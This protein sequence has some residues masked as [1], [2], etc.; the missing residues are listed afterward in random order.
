MRNVLYT[1]SNWGLCYIQSAH[2]QASHNGNYCV[3]FNCIN[4]LYDYLVF[5][6]CIACKLSDINNA[7]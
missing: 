2:M 4:A 5:K 6:P 7:L 3:K 1:S